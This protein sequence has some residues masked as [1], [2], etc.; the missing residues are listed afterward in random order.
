[1]DF[2]LLCDKKL[3]EA[4]FISLGFFGQ[5]AAFLLAVFKENPKYLLFHVVFYVFLLEGIVLLST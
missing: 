2:G 1:M 5:I 3:I 4:S